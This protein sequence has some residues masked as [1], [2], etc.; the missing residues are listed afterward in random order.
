MPPRAH[1]LLES[2]NR[3][4]T[5]EGQDDKDLLAQ[6]RDRGLLTKERMPT[7]SDLST[8]MRLMNVGMAELL[9]LPVDV[10]NGMLGLAG[11]GTDRP[12]GGAESVQSGMAS[13]GMTP[14]PGAETE[15][16]LHEAGVWGHAARLAGSSAILLPL[17]P[18]GAVLRGAGVASTIVRGIGETAIRAPGAFATTEIVAGGVA[19]GG[20]EIAAMIHPDT[21][22]ARALGEIVGG[23]SAGGA[24][25]LALWA[26]KRLARFGAVASGVRFMTRMVGGFTPGQG[27]RLAKERMRSTVEDEKQAVRAIDDPELRELGFTPAQ[28]VGTPDILALE[29]SVMEATTALKGQRETTLA[30]VN[31]A[32]KNTL[33][34]VAGP[35]YADPQDAKDYL[36]ALLDARLKLAAA[37][38][39]ERL[40][41][42]GPTATREE[43]NILVREELDAVDSAAKQQQSDLW[44]AV[45]KTDLMETSSARDTLEDILKVTA[46]A[47]REDIPADAMNVL[48]KSRTKD[49]IEFYDELPAFEA[50]GLRSKLLEIGRQAHA[51]GNLNKSRIANRIAT[52]IGEDMLSSPAISEPF[53]LA[54]AFSFQYHKT[55]TQGPVGK[56]L[57]YAWEGGPAVPAGLTL[58]TTL[59]RTGPR[60]REAYDALNRAI[61]APS[62]DVLDRL[63]KE[64]G[65]TPSLKGH[66]ENFFVDE[67]RRAA[68]RN[69][70]LDPDKAATYLRLRQDVLTRLPELRA[71]METAMEMGV[72]LRV[73]QSMSEPNTA[74]AAIYIGAE[75][76][77]EIRKVIAHA[78]PE[79]RMKALFELTLHDETGRAGRGLKASMIEYLTQQAKSAGTDVTGAPIFSGNNILRQ[80][81][82]RKI[83]AAVS[84]VFTEDEIGRLREIA[85]HLR[86]LELAVSAKVAKGGVT[87]G[88]AGQARQTLAKVLGAAIGRRLQ[89][90]TIQAPGAM[91]GLFAKLEASGVRRPAERLIADAIQDETLFKAVFLDDLPASA[92]DRQRFGAWMAGVVAELTG[93]GGLSEEWLDPSEEELRVEITPLPLDERTGR[94]QVPDPSEEQ[95]QALF[96]PQPED[97]PPQPEDI[98]PPSQ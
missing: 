76:G 71:K 58:E 15:A 21:P 9:G 33:D 61:A 59:G 18:F 16:E 53:D 54:R 34:E 38:A 79:A 62:D 46:K 56:A 32:I 43:V 41:E 13:L 26:V 88:W 12:F 85:S 70:V 42:L 39:E 10:V 86:R 4:L 68:V 8:G 28:R 5:I 22:G 89:T 78:D 83:G 31:L 63:T 47:Q 20:G 25:S 94:Q 87:G 97:Q 84:G 96:Q 27:R 30:E 51:A 44:E 69:G 95:Y 74:A 81:D 66:A 98:A 75:P 77:A 80:L 17:A 65:R 91:A 52:A 2:E 1:L 37:R 7:R 55:F 60:G 48:I 40:A 45:P 14:T 64:L 49:G 23:F 93:E 11:L 82:D 6:L 3:G 67:F 92:A 19:G 73:T 90:G 24:T 29:R 36:S 50:Q 57:G 72:D 35:G